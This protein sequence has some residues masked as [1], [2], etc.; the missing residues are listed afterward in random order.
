MKKFFKWSAIIAGIL[1]IIGLVL[2]FISTAIGGR[3]ALFTVGEGL[4]EVAWDELD[5]ATQKYDEDSVKDIPVLLDSIGLKIVRSK[6]RLLTFKM[7]EFY[8]KGFVNDKSDA[9]ELF[10]KLPEHVQYSNYKQANFIV[11]ILKE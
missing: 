6:I 9:E 2:V 8:E 11:K 1:M 10:N 4:K 7:H 5:E 3:R